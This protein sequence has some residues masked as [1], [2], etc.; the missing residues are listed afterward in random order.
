M[1]DE[2]NPPDRSAA[3]LAGPSPADDS[4]EP[5]PCPH[6]GQMLAPTCR[7][8]VSCRQ[9]IDPA[10]IRRAPP[11]EL[12]AVPGG[13]VKSPLPGE[14][15]PLPALPPVRYPWRMFL[16]VLALTWVGAVL[17][18]E[19]LGLEQGRILVTGVQVLSSLWVFFDARQKRLP[20]P[21]HWG[22]GT[23]F[24]WIIM[25]P[26][27]LVRRQRP[28]APCPFVERE[29]SPL[30]RLLLAALALFFLVAVVVT[31]LHGPK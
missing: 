17:A 19:F 7:V 22:I 30:A 21:F 29:A 20:K 5:F 16:L 23:L 25:F 18:L 12:A 6:C 2:F 4:E 15:T 14:P 3:E 8:C 13:D 9:A 24:L 11:V 26:W 31:L 27:Y 1:T 28:Q 10:D